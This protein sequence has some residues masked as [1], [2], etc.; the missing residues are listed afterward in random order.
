MKLIKETT[1]KR[2]M[3]IPI[4]I[5]DINDEEIREVRNV[6]LE[7]SLTSSSF[8]GGTRVQQ[9]E[10]LLSKFV[11]SK[12]AIA[13]NSGTSALQASLY[14]LN[15]KSGDEVLIPSFTFKKKNYKTI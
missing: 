14:A 4:N 12:F 7:K 6:L 2:S 15:I 11:K 9:F 13:V 5:P 1:M 10:N 3:K 8:D